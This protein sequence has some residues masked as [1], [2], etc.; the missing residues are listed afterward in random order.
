MS[1][2]AVDHG[3]PLSFRHGAMRERRVLMS[4]RWFGLVMLLCLMGCTPHFE[5]P[6]LTVV[7][8]ELQKGNLMQQTF[9]VRFH[10]QNP[11]KRPLPV[12]G[13][14]ADLTVAGDKVA[15][16][17][18]NHPFVVPPEGETDFDMTIT[19]NNMALT[20]LKLATSPH[21]DSIDYLV[22]GVANLDLPFMHELPFQQ[23]GSFALHAMQ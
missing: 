16:G 19:A 7:G 12:A 3:K 9:L 2:E 15:T 21:A 22:T 13:L 17:V 11:N 18:T 4:R 8:L 6:V 23:H 1:L 10:I 14:H 5:R 20:I